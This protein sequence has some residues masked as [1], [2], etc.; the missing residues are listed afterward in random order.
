[1]TTTVTRQIHRRR[2]RSRTHFGAKT[3]LNSATRLS[4]STINSRSQ[5]ELAWIQQEFLSSHLWELKLWTT[6]SYHL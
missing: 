3:T 4:K 6:D 1:M 5:S 2:I